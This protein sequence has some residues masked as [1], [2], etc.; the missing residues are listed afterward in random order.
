MKGSKVDR[1]LLHEYLW[2]VRDRFDVVK[3]DQKALSMELSLSNFTISHLLKKMVED[4]QLQ[5]L[6]NSKFI[7]NDPMTHRLNSNKMDPLF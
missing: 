4:G 7:V 6:G 2:S 3:I 1:G 5:R